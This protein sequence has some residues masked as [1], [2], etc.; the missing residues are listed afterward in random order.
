MRTNYFIAILKIVYC[1]VLFLIGIL[2]SVI[3]KDDEDIIDQTKYFQY[4]EEIYA[5]HKSTIV[6]L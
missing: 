2:I 6:K 1:F 3:L 4:I 5:D